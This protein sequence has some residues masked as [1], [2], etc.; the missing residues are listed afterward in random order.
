MALR[1]CRVAAANGGPVGRSHTWPHP[2]H[3]A[4][5]AAGLVGDGPPLIDLSGAEA[6]G[7]LLTEL[8]IDI[9]PTTRK[10]RGSSCPISCPCRRSCSS[11]GPRR[12]IGSRTPWRGCTRS[13]ST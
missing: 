4:S 12:V 5:L 11:T 1:V 6:P 9:R 8:R 10:A 7:Y 13:T 3:G 2:V